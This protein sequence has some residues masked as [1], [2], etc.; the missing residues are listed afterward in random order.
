MLDAYHSLGT[1]NPMQHPYLAELGP[2]IYA[3]INADI[4]FGHSNIGLIIDGD[5]LTV[6][7]TGPT[8]AY[9]QLVQNQIKE[10]IGELD[11]PLKRC[12]VT[13]SR[14][15]FTG[16]SAA[17]W[18]AAFYGSD[19]TSGQLDGPVNHYA[20][21]RLLPDHAGHYGDEFKTRPVTHEVSEAA[22][23]TPS[24]QCLA[25][26]GESPSTLIAQ[27]VEAGVLFAGA[28]ASFGVT[29]LA[30]DAEPAAWADSLE[31]VAAQV[32][33]VVPG[34]GAIG[35]SGELLTQAAY[36]RACVA[37][38]GELGQLEKGP[39]DTWTNPEYHAI[40][41]ERAALVARGDSNPPISFLQLLG[42]A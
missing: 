38:N 22:W 29:P 25:I 21:R 39:W 33:T 34:H 14:V 4:G 32:D 36:L 27:A 5:G 19:V 6:I 15:P 16:G 7:D 20:I 26:A 11:L 41:V 37:A 23:I 13:S 24:T 40:N 1:L 3:F 35:G 28:F 30:F 42:L 2:G 10:L 17:Y 31:Q 12:V 18:Q 9:G 8:P